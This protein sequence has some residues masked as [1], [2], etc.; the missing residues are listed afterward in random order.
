VRASRQLVPALAIA[1]AAVASSAWASEPTPAA[2]CTSSAPA[3][4]VAYE[5]IEGVPVSATSLDIYE[6]SAECRVAGAKAPVVIWVHGGGYHRGD[7]SNQ[8][9]DKMK[10][11]SGLGYIFISVNYRLTAMGDPDSAHYPDHF[12]DVA[13]AVAWVRAKI[14]TRGGD[15]SRIALL[16]H[17]A[18]A[19]IVSNVAVNPTWLEERGL[20]L[21]ALRCAGPLDTEGFDKVRASDDGDELQWLDSLGNNP[22]YKTET[23]ASH[24]IKANTGIPPTITVFRGTTLRQSIES[25]FA[26]RLRAVGVPVTLIDARSLSH[27]EVNTRIGA[28]GD[29]VMTRPIVGFLADCLAPTPPPK[30]SLRR[31]PAKVVTLLGRR[32]RVKV[33]F[34]F[35]AKTAAARFQCRLGTSAYRACRSPRSYRVAPGKHVFAVRA[36]S[37]QGTGPARTFRFRVKRRP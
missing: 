17:S 19:D 9:A 15:P 14:A 23:S 18:G 5:R 25:D 16:G 35:A 2:G 28:A 31:H 33:T 20:G 12:R 11:F 32:H 29:E 22:N 34:A 8:V 6:P 37:D 10:L 27:G 24:L 13:A 30:P 1:A 4:T 26:A 7:K 36:V 3:E 21:R